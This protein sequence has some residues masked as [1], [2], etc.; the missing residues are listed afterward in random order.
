MG[1]SRP[2]YILSSNCFASGL[3]RS[4]LLFG[5][6]VPKHTGHTSFPLPAPQSQNPLLIKHQLAC[7]QK[8]QLLKYFDL[9]TTLLLIHEVNW[10]KKNLNKRKQSLITVVLLLELN[11]QHWMKSAIS[12]SCTSVAQHDHKELKTTKIFDDSKLFPFQGKLARVLNHYAVIILK[13]FYLE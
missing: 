2:L 5:K 6:P 9:L 12:K 4:P 11:R 10:D 1:N 8:S 13:I 7:S 3:L